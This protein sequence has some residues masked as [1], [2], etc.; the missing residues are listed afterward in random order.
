M[1]SV[2]RENSLLSQNL[3]QNATENHL[4]LYYLF[5]ALAISHLHVTTHE[6]MCIRMEQLRGLKSLPKR[7]QHLLGRMNTN[8]LGSDGIHPRALLELSW[9]SWIAYSIKLTNAN[10]KSS[11]DS[12]LYQY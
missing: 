7:I 2:W 10:V 5:V 1:G 8:E 6:Q 9:N 11:I 3:A 12:K 4:A